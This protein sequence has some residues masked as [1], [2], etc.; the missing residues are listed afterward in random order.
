MSH[1]WE[2]DCECWSPWNHRPFC[3]A[4]VGWI[5]QSSAP[6]IREDI[7]EAIQRAIDSN[8]ARTTIK[9]FGPQTAYCSGETTQRERQ[10]CGVCGLF[11]QC[12]DTTSWYDSHLS[13][14]Q[15]R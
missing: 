10:S 11:G 15:K 2:T 4:T 6:I 14:L 12:C 5:A 7:R 9:L 8:R 13:D 1:V 3:P